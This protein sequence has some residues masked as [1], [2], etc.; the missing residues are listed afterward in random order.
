MSID[1]INLNNLNKLLI[2]I[3][4]LFIY[5][6]YKGDKNGWHLGNVVPGYLLPQE[7]KLIQDEKFK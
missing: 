2:K 6:N 1:W 7:E 3:I 4:V 5:R